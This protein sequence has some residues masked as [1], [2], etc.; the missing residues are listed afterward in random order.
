MAKPAATEPPPVA[1]ANAAGAERLYQ[2]E[3]P[4]YMMNAMGT[5]VWSYGD[6]L[7]EDGVSARDVAAMHFRK[8]FFRD[9]VLAG[10][11][12]I[13]DTAPMLQIKKAVDAAMDK[14]TA[15]KKFLPARTRGN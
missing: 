3:R 6:I 15:I 11:E 2:P 7:A 8:L 4:G 12:L 10:A 13:G 1:G 9:G 5:K 14:E